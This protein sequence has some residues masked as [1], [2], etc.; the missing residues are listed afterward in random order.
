MAVQPWA[1]VAADTK[2]DL[3]VDPAGFLA[4]A[5]SAYSAQFPLGQLQ[6]QA[7]GYLF[8][9]GLFFLLTDF[10]PDW[11]AQRLWWTLVVGVGYSGFLVLLRRIDVG[12][13]AFRLLAAALFAFSPRT[14][15]TLTAI[16]S[17][18]WPVML[19]PWVV[20]AVLSPRLDHRALVGAVVP[21]ALMGAVNASATLLACLPAGIAL[22]WRVF[23]SRESPGRG[24]GFAF[25]WLLGC[26]LVS[27][28]WIGPLL[29]LG[30]YSAPFT[31]F[32][33]SSFVTNRWLNLAEILRGT[34]S[35]SPFVDTERTA[36]ALLALQPVYVLVTM[37][38]AAAGLVGLCLLRQRSVWL[39]MLFAGIALLGAAYGPFAAG[40]LEL[41]DGPLAAFR[42]IHK[43]DPLVR[44][45]LL[46]GVAHLGSRLRLPSS[47]AE[48]ARPGI[49]QA[50]AVLVALV[51]LAAVSPALSARLLPT[52][53]W[54]DVPGYWL[55][56]T[57]FLN[58]NAAG[59]RTLLAPETP[60]A[61][62]D[63]GWT[64]D[65]PAQPLLDVPWAVRDAIPLVD[66]EAIRGLDG[67]MT[68][69]HHLPEQ[70]GPA[71]VEAGIGAVL[72]RHDLATGS[73]GDAIDTDALAESVPGAQ[74]HDFGEIEV[75]LLDPAAGPTTTDVQPV[76]VAGGGESVALLDALTK[77]TPRE[78]VAADADVVTDT[79][80]AVARNYG[81][82]TDPVSAPLAHPEEGAD[83]RNRVRDYPS[84][85]PLTRVAEHGLRVS[86]SSS[87]ADATAFGGADAAES[88]TASVDKH[89]DTAWW[90]APGAATGEWL[91]LTADFV[92]QERVRITATD[93]SEVTV[94]S[95]E[96]ATTVALTGGEETEVVVP[97][98]ATGAI[99]VTLQG[100]AAVGIAEISVDGYPAERVV[101][102]PD[103]SPNVRQFLFQRLVVDT[104]VLVRDFTA[105]RAMTVRLDSDAPV[106][107]DDREHHP[108]DILELPAGTH[109]LDTEATW[110]TLTEPDFAP[111]PGERIYH[112]GLSANEG[113]R[114][115]V[116]DTQLEPVRVGAGMQGFVLP[117]GV[118]GPVEVSFAGE[119]AYRG[120]LLAGGVTLV[121]TLLACAVVGLRPRRGH[122]RGEL[123]EGSPLATVILGLAALFVVAGPAGLMAAALVAAIRRFTLIRASWLAAGLVAV[124]GAWLARSPW[125]SPTYAGDV[126]ILQWVLA[127]AVA[128]SLPGLL[129]RTNRAPG[130]SMNS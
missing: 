64:R 87:A 31:E 25:L 2:L 124:A 101:T 49:R 90:P 128:C 11:I 55:E 121:L 37:A 41:L 119:R 61:R 103:T 40:W 53:T 107:I 39:V 17:E 72:V 50:G 92:G 54:Q 6:N 108:G 80:L 127:A 8:P 15:T 22:L 98:P 36:G 70:A 122:T 106:L 114:A 30:R 46:I 9:H 96:A 79:P 13:P 88:V 18:A 125:P 99:R 83:V 33:E 76:R 57:D 1:E 102:V 62:Q 71:L 86:A 75:V 56:A 3:M 69:L 42:N 81:T 85:G 7:Y 48:F 129:P 23:N 117:E 19:S 95:G 104:G 109:R 77:P 89:P 59:T 45:P 38:V 118:S 111:V 29:V 4:G 21:V 47:A 28:W 12:S 73:A 116:G 84:A 67:M 110:V 94:S 14:L 63:W 51:A 65:E 130:S 123:P 24:A 66:P 97:G 5:A 82:L 27:A 16:S 34:T 78:L 60:F 43:A 68:V 126:D 20:A 74:I 32:I 115:H 58:D 52:G 44:I 91:E 35:W 93:D 113:L 112:S 100:P 105:P 26:A 120:S 10:L